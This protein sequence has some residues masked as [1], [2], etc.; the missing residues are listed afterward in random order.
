MSCQSRRGQHDV[1][2]H[3]ARTSRPMACEL[4]CDWRRGGNGGAVFAE[5]FSVPLP[6]C[7]PGGVLFGTAS[8]VVLPRVVT[9]SSRRAVRV[10]LRAP[11]DQWHH[12]STP[13][14]PPASPHWPTAWG[15][16]SWPPPWA[17]HR[18]GAPRC[19]PWGGGSGGHCECHTP[20]PRYSP[21]LRRSSP[22]PASGS[23][24]IRPP[25]VPVRLAAAAAQV[26]A[27]EGPGAAAA[28]TTQAGTP[29]AAQ[30]T[31]ASAAPPTASSVA[32][33]AGAAAARGETAS[34]F[35]QLTCV[36]GVVVC[37]WDKGQC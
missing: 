1:P 3:S 21:P 22:S 7:P 37:S 10:S 18:P 23:A 30:P 13:T 31:P 14:P 26:G 25:P 36:S 16:T 20:P 12:I 28:A 24:L 11:C 6:A 32:P 29:E 34:Q 17:G 2:P 4:L 15:S 8:L 33:N 19:V 5:N 27:G 35:A 9:Q